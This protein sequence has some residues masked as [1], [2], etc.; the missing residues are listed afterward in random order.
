MSCFSPL[1]TV[2]N[3]VHSF[4]SG[5]TNCQWGNNKLSVSLHLLV[6]MHMQ[7]Y[8]SVDLSSCIATEWTA[9]MQTEVREC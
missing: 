4:E 5:I 6:I 9:C 3:F 7:I 2:V 8:I 1:Y